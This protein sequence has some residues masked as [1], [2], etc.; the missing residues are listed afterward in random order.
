M[1]WFKNPSLSPFAATAA[2]CIILASFG[3]TAEERSEG[4][5]YNDSGM[6][7]HTPDGDCLRTINWTF[8][9]VAIGTGGIL[10]CLAERKTSLASD[11]KEVLTSYDV[12]N[13]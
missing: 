2:A 9:N 11:S 12:I 6:I 3:A 1:I 4:Y 7:V 5:V 13:Q 10:A 8:K